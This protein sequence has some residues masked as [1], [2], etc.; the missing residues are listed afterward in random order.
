GGPPGGGGPAKQPGPP[1]GGGPAKQPGPPG[2][3]GPPGGSPEASTPAGGPA[4]QPE[5]SAPSPSSPAEEAAA[6][7]PVSK[8][9]RRSMED[10]ELDDS[11]IDAA[12]GKAFSAPVMILLGIVLV[13]GVIFGVFVSNSMNTREIRE[14]RSNDAS[15]ILDEIKPKIEAYESVSKTINGL[16]PT[17]PNFEAAESMADKEIAPDGNLLGGNRL[18]LSPTAIDYVTSYTVDSNMLAQMLDEHK[19]ITTKVDKKELEELAEGNEIVKKDKFALL[20]NYGHLAKQSGGEN[21]VPEPG[22]LVT[23]KSLEK[24]DEGEIQVE[25]LGSDSTIDTKIQSIIPI[26]KSEMMKTGGQNAMQ[27]YT[28]RVNDLQ[29]QVKRIEQYRELLTGELEDLANLEAAP[30]LSF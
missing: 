25:L 7:E 8:T 20:F 10:I 2:G 27:R 3:G 13:V 12:G 6:S 22:R 24:N 11:D 19:R 5:P 17:E 14:A 23:V 26:K 16:N 18:L 1:G 4:R 9:P 28:N 15:R 30:L 21:Y 29:N